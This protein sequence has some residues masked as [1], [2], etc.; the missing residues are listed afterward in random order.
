M[1]IYL[2]LN[3]RQKQ[4]DRYELK[5]VFAEKRYASTLK[6][7]YKKNTTSIKLSVNKFTY[8]RKEHWRVCFIQGEE[9]QHVGRTIFIK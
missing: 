6:C 7:E 4:N 1:N 2:D 8:V 5:K 3:Y 9:I